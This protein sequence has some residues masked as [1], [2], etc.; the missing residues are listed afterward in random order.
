[1]AAWR[2]RALELFPQLRRDLTAPDAT[3]GTLFSELKWLARAAHAADDAET[4]RR[5][6]GFAEWC[7][8]QTAKE[9]W[10]A[11]GVV[12]YEHVF[13]PPADPER[14]AL[15][16]SPRVVHDHWDLW[17]AMLAPEA[18]ATVRPLLEGKRAAFLRESGR[19]RD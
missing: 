15:W 1:M 5:I 17:E 2:R 18:W 9:L 8:R 19:G 13:D 4:L 6:Y 14:V 12:F 3:P 11:A 10:N 16:L 7:S